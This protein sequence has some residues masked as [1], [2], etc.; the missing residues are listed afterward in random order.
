MKKPLM[1][2][3]TAI[4]L[5]EN[6]TIS[7]DQIAE[8]CHL[9]ELEVQGIAD[10][11]VATGMQGYDP[12]DNYQLT[13]EEIARCEKDSTARLELISSTVLG[14]KLSRTVDD[15]NPRLAVESFSQR[16]ISSFVN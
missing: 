4:W 13:K 8:F 11:D 14:G 3:A 7:F 1:P 12:I 2:K 10:D 9:H 5:I 6:T 15:I 16:A